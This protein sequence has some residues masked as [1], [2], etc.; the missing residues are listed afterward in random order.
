[1][2]ARRSKTW[3]ASVSAPV[4]SFSVSSARAAW[5]GAER[6][7][8]DGTLFSSTRFRRFG[9]PALRKYFCARMSAATWLKFSGTAKSARRKMTVPSGFLISLVARRNGMDA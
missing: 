3:R 9:T 2:P 4:R 7:S 5:S 1:V 8:H 6:H